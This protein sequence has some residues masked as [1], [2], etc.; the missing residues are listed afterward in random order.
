MYDDNEHESSN[1]PPYVGLGGPVGPPAERCKTTSAED[2]QFLDVMELESARD[3][4][5]GDASIFSLET[6]RLL[7][8]NAPK[9]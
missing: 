8:K 6:S 3:V 9:G 7:A 2:K 1:L 4:A 5:R